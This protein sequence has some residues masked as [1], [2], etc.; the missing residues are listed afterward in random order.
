MT[1]TRAAAGRTA[2]GVLVLAGLLALLAGCGDD[3]SDGSTAESGAGGPTLA[4]DT[5]APRTL[6]VT[7]PGGPDGEYTLDADLDGL[8]AGPVTVTLTNNGTLEHQAMVLRLRDGQDAGSF[9]AAAAA[10]PTGTEAL[11][12]V[13]GYGGPNGVGPGDTGST[14][15]VLESGEYLLICV[16]PGEDG[17][18]HAAHGM[19]VPFSVGA[20]EGGPARPPVDDPADADVSLVDFGFS[21][22][23]TFE[24]GD[25]VTVANDGEQAHEL[26]I[27]RRG[28][29]VTFEQAEAALRD[30]A[31]GPPPLEPAGGIGAL[32]PGAAAQLTLPDEPG[33]YVLVCFIPEVAGDGRPHSAH[34]MV[35]ELP[36]P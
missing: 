7:I 14:T 32:A 13:E 22:D 9:V 33:D 18:P 5:P 34:G 29:D 6:D 10:D 8:T 28:D 16:I 17:L 4:P 11:S 24:P 26:A 23:G 27:Y 36:L 1:T 3:G 20:A 31:A 35:T 12:L 2:G 15:Q 25:A 30:P 19:L 21:V